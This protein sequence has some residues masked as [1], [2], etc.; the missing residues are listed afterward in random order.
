MK[1]ILMLS[2]F[3]PP[4][5]GGVEKHTAAVAGELARRGYQLTIITCCH[6]KQLAKIQKQDKLK[7]I[8]IS[9]SR[10]K[11][12]G[13]LWI[14]LQIYWHL[15]FTIKGLKKFRVVH[16]HD[17]MVWILPLAFVKCLFWPKLKLVLTIHGWEGKYP[18]P[19][20]NIL[21][22][23]IAVFLADHTIGV[24]EY[25]AKYYKLTSLHLKVDSWIYG[26]L[27]N[28]FLTTKKP[29]Q[30]D[31]IV[32]K[33]SKGKKFQQA[34]YK[35]RVFYLGRLANDTPL[36]IFLQAI[37]QMLPMQRQK[38]EFVFGGEGELRSQAAKLGQVLGVVDPLPQ[39]QKA[40][41]CIASGYLSILEALSQRCFVITA[42]DN[43][44][45]KD[46]YQ[47]TPF[48]E[49]LSIADSSQDLAKNL[50]NFAENKEIR[51]A[52]QKQ[53]SAVQAYIKKQT[54]ED[55]T[56]LYQQYY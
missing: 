23:K 12:F 2:P 34:C 40:D 46:Y 21:L 17:V 47:Q 4:H 6:K 14:W 41:I 19:Y 22:K 31:K 49:W 39:L 51:L 9:T 38:F 28:K 5:V 26:A 10:V 20:K 8:R 44:L 56:K 3:Y 54:W 36:P 33:I 50:L 1:Q 30:V 45:K 16:V 53:Q 32:T 29:A 15:I 37:E 18:I 13:L 52:W 48:A 11:Y 55:I 27:D 24:G 25:L 43:P 35:W 42:H 7:I